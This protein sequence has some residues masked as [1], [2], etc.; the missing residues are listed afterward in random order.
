M[1]GYNTAKGEPS[2]FVTILIEYF[3][4]INILTEK[5]AKANI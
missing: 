5:Y 1:S 3:Y 2:N 4:G